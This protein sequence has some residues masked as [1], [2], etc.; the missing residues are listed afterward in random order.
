MPTISVILPT[1]N[2]EKLLAEA[3]SSVLQQTYTDYELIVVDDG[4]TDDT[5]AVLQPFMNRI[6][7]ISQENGGV[8]HARN[9]GVSAATGKW[10]AFHDSDNVWLPEKLEK[11]MN[12]IRETNSGIY[13]RPVPSGL[14]L[15]IRIMCTYTIRPLLAFRQCL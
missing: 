10:V 2:R 7:Y 6:R 5:K 12:V 11:Q 1:Y 8:S 9:T 4:S 14:K 3:V 13:R 15:T